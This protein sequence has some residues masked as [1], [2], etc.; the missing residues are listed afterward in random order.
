MK[1]N[2]GHNAGKLTRR[3]F[4]HILVAL[5]ASPAIL[6]WLMVGRRDMKMGVRQ[7]SLIIGKAIPP[8]VSFIDFAIVV[9]NNDGVSAYEAKCT[10]LGCRISKIEGDQLVCPCH[11]SRYSLSGKLVKGPA[12]KNLKKLDIKK[13]PLSG[14]YIVHKRD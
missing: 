11:G 8:G 10:H 6:W 2:S 13:D 9:N 1:T 7:Q 3:G 4:F 5:L 12:G 14:E